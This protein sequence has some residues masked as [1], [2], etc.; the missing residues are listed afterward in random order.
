MAEHGELTGGLARG[1]RW[2]LA[3][4]LAALLVVGGCGGGGSDTKAKA[5][6]SSKS[7]KSD[8]G[9]DSDSTDSDSDSTD[10][11]SDSTDSDSDSTDSGATTAF[12][13]DGYTVELPAGWQQQVQSDDREDT[14]TFEKVNDHQA[15]IQVRPNNSGLDV[16]G[17]L[18]SVLDTVKPTDVGDR[19]PV[20]ID[21]E[22]GVQQFGHILSSGVSVD[23][24][25]ID[26]LHEGR[27]YQLTFLE[28][29]GKERP[30]LLA[31]FR[32]MQNSLRF[33]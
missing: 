23:I 27:L 12:K 2:G 5:S 31:D 29:A 18:D 9:S 8:S 20:T 15:R 3:L 14:V 1:R 32:S 22:Q 4:G 6:S 17:V 33:T 21:G 25:I 7:A 24:L 30:E 19:A 11:D 13:G 26:V 16:D 28:E 10:S